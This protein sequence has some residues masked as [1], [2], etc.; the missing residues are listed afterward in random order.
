MSKAKGNL[1]VTPNTNGKVY[2]DVKNVSKAL[3]PAAV[4]CML[5]ACGGSSGD[6]TDSLVPFDGASDV[7][8]GGLV[9]EDASAAPSVSLSG[10]AT[11]SVT[12]DLLIQNA[13]VSASAG[14]SHSVEFSFDVVDSSGAAVSLQNLSVALEIA[15]NGNFDDSYRQVLFDIRTRDDA[16][17]GSE[18]YALTARGSAADLPAGNYSARLVVN[19]NWQ[20]AFDI[21]PADRDQSQPF[22]FIDEAD[23]GNN[24]SNAFALAVQSGMTCT[25]DAFEDNDSVESAAL[26][27]VGGQIE[28]SLCMDMVDF[29]AIDLAAG[30]STSIYFDA[31]DDRGKA[32]K[33]VLLD[34]NFEIISRSVAR[35]SN[36]IRINATAA[37]RYTLAVYGQRSSYMLMREPT[38]STSLPE[39]FA[40][41]FVNSAFFTEESI[42]GP[43]SW[44]LGGIT[45][46]KLA[47]NET[48]LEGQV[49]ECGRI[50][51]Q[52]QDD[53]PVAYV[54]PQHFA[55][56][57]SFRFLS[58]GNYLVD[59]ELESGWAVESGDIQNEF[60]YAHDYPGYAEKI[61][62]HGWRYWT[63]DGLSY[64]EC[65][66]EI[67]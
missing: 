20:N 3:G 8:A 52:F 10:L 28:A 39:N 13:A 22:H 27:P 65:A 59:G 57:Y 66:I 4:A 17:T 47:F 23:Y 46:H 9:S 63:A 18:V 31:T 29:F 15:A 53:Q 1:D 44:Q 19:P 21:V 36:D 64:V 14:S 32:S 54:T 56:N 6:L 45:L 43:Q 34:T 40:N 60:W 41:D 50:T 51:T 55:D 61:D 24:A 33:Y 12:N 26:I 37:G 67:N 7:T 42:A 30:E 2:S 11:T 49:V 38:F 25:E 58:G 48:A 62:E 16:A 35:E 5:T